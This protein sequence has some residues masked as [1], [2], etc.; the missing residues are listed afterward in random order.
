LPPKRCEVCGSQ[1]RQIGEG[2]F[3]ACEKC[4]LVYALD[5]RSREEGTPG[6]ESLP[7]RKSNEEAEVVGEEP[8]K[9]QV[10]S[11]DN[12]ARWRCP[13]CEEVLTADNEADMKFV[14]REHVREFHP[15]RQ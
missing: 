6:N 3:G 15:N 2:P 7:P 8:I 11:D 1:V 14:I 5:L 12:R 9:G 13:D 10:P 4:G